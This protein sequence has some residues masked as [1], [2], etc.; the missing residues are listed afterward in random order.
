M[1]RTMD[2]VGALRQVFIFKDVPEDVLEL[3]AKAAEDTTVSA[4]DTI[5]AVGETPHALFVIRN[6]T[7]R[8]LPEGGKTPAVLFGT[9]ETIGEVS[10]I[11]GGPAGG[12]AT[13]LERVDL[14]V[15]RA[16]RLKE[17]LAG[18]PTAGHQLFRAVARSLAG[19]LRRAVGMIALAKEREGG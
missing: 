13:A 9:G 10:L 19:R 3:V 4:G 8:V 16:S 15:L 5:V 7:V 11:D 2:T 1:R 14:I 12:T 17:V 18:N 6:G